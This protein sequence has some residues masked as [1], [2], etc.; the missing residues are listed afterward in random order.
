LLEQLQAS[1]NPLGLCLVYNSSTINIHQ[2]SILITTMIIQIFC[3]QMVVLQNY[4]NTSQG[5]DFFHHNS[6]SKNPKNLFGKDAYF[7]KLTLIDW[8]PNNGVAH[9]N[10][11][12]DNFWNKDN[13]PINN[14]CEDFFMDAPILNMLVFHFQFQKQSINWN[15]CMGL[16]GRV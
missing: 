7:C 6:K 4:H 14:A 2:A 15:N 12:I 16:D 10:K 9:K 5:K 3:L 13:S 1:C 11:M 8:P